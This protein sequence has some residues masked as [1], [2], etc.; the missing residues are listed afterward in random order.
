[1]RHVIDFKI[2]VSN[3]M[4]EDLQAHGINAYDDRSVDPLRT[5][6]LKMNYLA[7]CGFHRGL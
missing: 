7:D 6:G 2:G 1:M 4:P 5:V 3:S